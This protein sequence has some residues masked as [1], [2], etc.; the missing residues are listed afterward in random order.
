MTI[1][2]PAGSRCP[3]AADRGRTGAMNS[4]DWDSG[5]W[6]NRGAGRARGA[7]RDGI[8]HARRM[9]N[10]SAA[11]LIV[12]TG[13]AVVALA[14]G[15]VPAAVPA[16][17]SRWPRGRPAT[18]AAGGRDTAQPGGH[19][20]DRGRHRAPTAS[21]SVATTSGS[22][23]TG[24]AAGTAAGQSAPPVSSSVATT[25]GSGVTTITTTNPVTGKKTVTRRSAA[26]A[27][28]T[29][30]Q[31][32][33]MSTTTVPAPAGSWLRADTGDDTVAVAER[34]VI[35]TTARVAVWPP[36]RLG[37]A[38]AAVDRVVADLDR[39]ASRFRPDSEIAWIHDRGGGLFMLSDGLAGL[40]GVALAAA[41][42]TGGRTDPTVGNAVIALGYD[43]DFAAMDPD[44]QADGLPPGPAP[45]C[46]AVRLDGCLLRLPHGITLDL[47]AT[48]KG[49][50]ADRAADAAR[51]AVG[52][53]AAFW[54]AWAATSRWPGPRR[55]A[56]G[57][58]WWR[59]SPSLRT[60]GRSSW[61]GS[62]LAGSPHPR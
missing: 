55:K 27:A 44:G 51:R 46:A 43:R 62:L 42:W 20:R 59:T 6:D 54:S 53:P 13:A 11:A 36:G 39:Q 47:G 14:R 61:S 5:D 40:I 33:G 38:L 45:G 12:G 15:T 21:H 23:V 56:A 2:R 16:P 49:V 37:P 17:A 9:S 10:W 25:S 24:T 60:A 29:T 35:G 4:G 28:G 22:G 3:A 30:D 31:E 32:A 19:G 58:C 34:P 41:R 7:R 1:T 18:P 8:G 48:A 52:P 57:R 50:G 26:A